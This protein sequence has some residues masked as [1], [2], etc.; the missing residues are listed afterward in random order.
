MARIGGALERLV[1]VG[2][3]FSRAQ[4]GK[5]KVL[6][7]I[8]ERVRDVAQVSAQRGTI[9]KDG[10]RNVAKALDATRGAVDAVKSKVRGAGG[11]V[12]GAGAAVASYGASKVWKASKVP[13]LMVLIFGVLHYFYFRNTGIHYEVS[14]LLMVLAGFAISYSMQGN[15]GSSEHHMGV[16]FVLAPFLGWFFVMGQSRGDFIWAAIFAASLAG[17]YL[18]FTKGTGKNSLV[19][20]VIAI[21]IFSMDLSLGTFFLDTLQWNFI[22]ALQTVLIL[23]PWYALTGVVTLPTDNDGFMLLKGLA[24]LLMFVLVASVF[25]PAFHNYDE[26]L[27]D[28]E[29]ITAIEEGVVA[30]TGGAKPLIDRLKIQVE[31]WGEKLDFAAIT[32]SGGTRSHVECLLAKQKELRYKAGCEAEGLNAGTK[33]YTECLSR[34]RKAD[35]LQALQVAGTRD[36]TITKPVELKL[37]I[38]AKSLDQPWETRPSIQA[39]FELKNPR[40]DETGDFV[41]VDFSCGFSSVRNPGNESIEGQ[42]Q[43]NSEVLVKREDFQVGLVC[44]P[45]QDLKGKYKPWFVARVMRLES[46][47]RLERAFIGRVENS[48]QQETLVKEVKMAIP[49]ARSLAPNDPVQI[50]FDIG[51]AVGDR[52]IEDSEYR[53]IL[54]R[55]ALRNKG[56]GVIERIHRYYLEDPASLVAQDLGCFSGGEKKLGGQRRGQEIALSACKVTDYD[57]DFKPVEDDIWIPVEFVYRVSYD[58]IMNTTGAVKEYGKVVG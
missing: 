34:Q 41:G 30:K 35:S 1:K 33:G 44:E 16:L 38:Y 11:A 42:T 17:I 24:I 9:E 47:S 29:R 37:E 20:G 5:A 56:K 53:S 3:A 58:Y 51:H 46:A 23:I 48:K 25:V 7:A 28:R 15:E 14:A 45:T 31:C 43:F 54:V 21:V 13:S 4:K 55:A 10:Q 49:E 8:G 57:S 12:A 26:V 36:P 22:P 50:D 52:V 2:R 39:D 18:W 6:A 27:P 32:Q 19:A 40:F